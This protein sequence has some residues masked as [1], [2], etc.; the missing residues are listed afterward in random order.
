MQEYQSEMAL[1]SAEVQK[2]Q[3]EVGEQ[4]QE[5]TLKTQNVAY[6]GK[7][8]DRYYQLAVQEIQRYISNNEKMIQ[9]TMAAQ[10]AQG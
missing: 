1:Y 5:N 9:Q 4:T 7:E 2:Y 3:I 6:Y 10:A 8:S